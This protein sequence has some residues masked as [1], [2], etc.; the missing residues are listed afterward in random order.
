MTQFYALI[1]ADRLFLQASALPDGV[2]S[3]IFTFSLVAAF[4]LSMVLLYRRFPAFFQ[5]ILRQAQQFLFPH[6]NKREARLERVIC[7]NCNKG[8]GILDPVYVTY[9]GESYIE[10]VC[11]CCGKFV[12]ARLR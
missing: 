6:A 2:R 4:G 3:A 8:M 12:R 10:G 1:P 9:H 11:N 7:Y 5:Q